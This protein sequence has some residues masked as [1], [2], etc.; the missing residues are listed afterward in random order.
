VTAED[1]DE[2]QV[3]AT[4]GKNP[5]VLFERSERNNQ[6]LLAVRAL[7]VPLKQVLTLLLEG[8]THQEVAE[9]LGISEN[10]V[11]VRANR[12]RAAVRVL[13]DQESRP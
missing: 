7:P 8:L 12:A 9:V 3:R 1:I 11:A 5:A 2:H 6:L 4:S 10:N 13:L